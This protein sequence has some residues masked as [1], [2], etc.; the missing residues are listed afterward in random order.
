MVN[1]QTALW[2][3][4]VSQ[5][6]DEQ[7]LE[8]YRQLTLDTEEPLLHIHLVTDSPVHIRSILYVPRRLDM[9]ALRLRPEHGVRLYSKKI[10]IQEESRELLPEYLAFVEG[11]VDSEDIPL[12]IS[13]ETVQSN[14]ILRAIQRALTN[15]VLKTLGELAEERPED[16]AT[17]WQAFGAFIKQG[18][19]TEF[20]AREDLVSL[21]RFPS[22]KTDGD[23]TTLA[24]YTERMQVDQPAIYYLL[25][26]G[27]GTVIQSPHLD[28]FKRHDLEVLYLTDPL[29]G[30]VMQSLREFEGHPLQNI[31][32]ADVQLPDIP[33]APPEEEAAAPVTEGAFDALLEHVRSA[34]GERVAD[35]RPSQLLR[36]SPCRLVSSESGMERDL[37][38]MR[39]LLEEDFE[40]PPRILELNRNHPLVRNLAQ[41]V[42]QGAA[43]EIVNAA[44]EQLFANQLLIEGLHPNPATMVPHIQTLLEAATR[45]E[46]A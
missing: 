3:E 41:R 45:T 8:F 42:Q 22:S 2:R 4:P 18:V 46:S 13:R 29:D 1:A 34:L 25:G 11:V 39:R 44:I 15:R 19:T 5:V 7:Y 16:Y 28:Y 9:G 36:D 35:V 27:L 24:A 10:L 12:N 30:V 26:E 21:L 32:S 40:I 33:E 43:D 38:R 37:Q 6:E 31:D 23:W 14:R 20:T 17:F